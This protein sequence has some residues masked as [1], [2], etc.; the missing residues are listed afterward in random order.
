M[1]I[2]RAYLC[3]PVVMREK[4]AVDGQPIRIC[5]QRA[6]FKIKKTGATNFYG[7]DFLH[8]RNPAALRAG[9]SARGMRAG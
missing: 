2:S 1:I 9:L 7:I 8:K 5:H 4:T 6:S 3:T